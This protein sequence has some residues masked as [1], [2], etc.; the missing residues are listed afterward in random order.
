MADSAL[1]AADSGVRLEKGG[2]QQ[3]LLS[4]DTLE[5]RSFED[6]RKDPK[7]KRYVQSID[8]TLQSFDA[9]NEWADVIG[10]LTRLAKVGSS[11][12]PNF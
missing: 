5:G 2:S 4:T 9:V 7:Y 1:P 11:T 3:D 12:Q 10:F 6:L 8:K